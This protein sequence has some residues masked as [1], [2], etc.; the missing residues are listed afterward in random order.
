[1]ISEKTVELNLT[2]E[3]LNWLFGV[4]NRTHFVLAPSQREEGRLGFDAGFYG[5]GPAVFIQF[6]R[7]YA[8]GSVMTWKLNRTTKKDQHKRLQQL[9]AVGVPVFYAF[10]AFWTEAHVIAGRQRLLTRTYW[11]K[12]TAIRLPGGPVGHHELHL[13]IT[14]HRW[15]VS[16]P[17]DKELNAIN[18]SLDQV[19][20]VFDRDWPE[21]A[22]ERALEKANEQIFGLAGDRRAAQP[23]Y[24]LQADD[25]LTAGLCLIGTGP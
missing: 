17:E 12:P 6:K 9:E 8:A 2:A 19:L 24:A 16:S 18:T 3:L 11:V 20:R 21:H 13:N 1:M 14:T 10:P 4:T 5:S 22:M 7:A 15:S 23:D 25:S